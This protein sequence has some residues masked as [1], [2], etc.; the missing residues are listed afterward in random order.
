MRLPFR[1]I[2]ILSLA[3]ALLFAGPDAAIAAELAPCEALTES[4]VR[5]VLGANWK[6]NEAFSKGEA[7]VYQGSPAATRDWAV[8]EKLATAAYGRLP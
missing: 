2:S 1:R 3:S 5:G 7:C 6:R 8:L 4:D